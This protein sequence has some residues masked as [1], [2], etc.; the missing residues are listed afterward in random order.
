MTGEILLPTPH[1]GQREVLGALKR[2]N[3]ISAG[4]RWR[5]TTMA[6]AHTIEKSACGARIGWGAPTYDQ[7]RIA[8][9]EAYRACGGVATVKFV[10][11]RMTIYFTSS[12]G[13][14]LFRSLD[15][16]DN[17]RGHSADGWVFDEVAD[18]KP[19]AY[20][21]VIYPMLAENPS[22]WFIGIGT[23][24]GRNWFWR[25]W[26]K[27]HDDPESQAWQI[28][29][30]GCEIVSGQLIRKPH[31]LENPEYLFEEAQKA[32]ERQPVD[33]FRQETL[34]EF[35][36]NSGAVFRNVDKA[37]VLQKT[38]PQDHAGHP[39]HFG[40]DWGKQ[41]DF[42]AIVGVCSKC[43]QVTFID[44]FNQIDYAFQRQRLEAH[45][46]RWKPVS[47]LPERN[48]MGEP[49]IEELYRAGV[50]VGV[51]PDRKL[52]F[53]TTAITKTPLIEELSLAIEKGDLKLL[54]DPIM[55]GE[56][57][58]YERQASK[59]GRPTY[60]APEGSHDDVVM[61]LALAWNAATT[62]GINLG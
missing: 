13:R 8:W 21:D 20:Y 14:I 44:R 26:L 48:S 46:H 37:A 38:R 12:G 29:T 56:L 54:D 10:Q 49:I 24:K 40:V 30:I 23:P 59:T 61:A 57:L 39:V 5:K 36:E 35:I 9:D 55:T 16:P 19:V 31:P 42:T 51:G 34:A 53:M 33:T 41:N 4:R 62:G 50:P 60:N 6:I 22:N 58:A 15:D 27:A 28:P 17:A 18:I 2:F 1:S 11:Q 3:W 45:V 47:V 52:G 25:E 43:M 7:V 32:F